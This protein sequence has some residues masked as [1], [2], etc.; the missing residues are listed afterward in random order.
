MSDGLTGWYRG[1]E[2][3]LVGFKVSCSFIC[4]VLGPMGMI[5]KEIAGLA[6]N[7]GRLHQDSLFFVLFFHKGL[8]LRLPD[9]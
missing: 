7:L 4:P 9:Y 6:Q 5:S 2:G 3:P 8:S 1:M